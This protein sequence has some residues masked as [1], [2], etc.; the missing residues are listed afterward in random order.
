[1]AGFQAD[2]V[3]EEIDSAMSTLRKAMKGI[4][5]RFQDFKRDH[6]KAARSVANLTVLITD[7]RMAFKN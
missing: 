4:P 5:I 6:D 2:R 7:A 1:M 3:C